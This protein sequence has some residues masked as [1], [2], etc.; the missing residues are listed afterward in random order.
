VGR[1]ALWP[2]VAAA[3]LVAVL[4]PAAVTLRACLA[5]HVCGVDEV[6]QAKVVHCASSEAA[7]LLRLALEE[8]AALPQTTTATTIAR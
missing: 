2:D 3:L 4:E 1:T 8:P 5:A 6:D 7:S